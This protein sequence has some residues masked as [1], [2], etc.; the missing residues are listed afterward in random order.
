MRDKYSKKMEEYRSDKSVISE[1]INE[2]I[3]SSALSKSKFVN[4]LDFV[5]KPMLITLDSNIKN[6]IES[7]N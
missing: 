6:R 3:V 4:D 5:E 2:E 7:I 1:I